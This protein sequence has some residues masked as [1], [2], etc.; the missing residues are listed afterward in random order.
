MTQRC[1]I[2]LRRAASPW[3]VIVAGRIVAGCVARV[4]DAH[5]VPFSASAAWV[6]GATFDREAGEAVPV[7]A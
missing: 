4:H 2:C 5:L 6:A 1:N 7:P 3:R